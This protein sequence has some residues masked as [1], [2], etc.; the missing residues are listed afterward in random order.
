MTEIND[1]MN[2]GT[3]SE[4]LLTFMLLEAYQILH[5]NVGNTLVI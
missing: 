1:Q 3:F 2:E 5:K 4:G